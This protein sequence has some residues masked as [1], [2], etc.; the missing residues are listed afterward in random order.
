MDDE[1]QEYL[2]LER[3]TPESILCV[4]R[5]FWQKCHEFA[6]ELGPETGA[7]ECVFL[8][9]FSPSLMHPDQNTVCGYFRARYSW[10]PK[11]RPL[12]YMAFRLRNDATLKDLDDELVGIRSDWKK[13]IVSND[14]TLNYGPRG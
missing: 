3:R 12:F 4:P 10:A 7:E 6:K 14:G 2:V 5:N 1:T 8:G 11:D 9:F 13:H